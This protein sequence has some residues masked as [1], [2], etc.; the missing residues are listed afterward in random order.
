MKLFLFNIA[1]DPVVNETH[2]SGVIAETQEEAIEIYSERCTNRTDY[3]VT[4]FP[5][6]SGLVID[7]GGHDFI[8]I[9]ARMMR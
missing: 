9:A 5:I 6:Q 8:S 2:G 7:A 3:E 4:E 1:G